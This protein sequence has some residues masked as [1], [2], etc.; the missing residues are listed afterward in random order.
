LFH[1]IIHFHYL[2]PFHYSST[3]LD[4]GTRWTWV[5]IF[6]LKPLYSRGKRP[7]YP[8]DRK[9]GGPQS[10]SG[11]CGIKKRSLVPAENRTPAC[12]RSQYRLSCS[13]S[14]DL[15]ETELWIENINQ[16][17]VQLW[18][19]PWP[20]ITHFA[21]NELK[22]SYKVSVRIAN[23]NY[24]VLL[25]GRWGRYLDSASVVQARTVLF[26]VCLFIL[27]F[28]LSQCCRNWVGVVTGWRPGFDSR[29]GK[30][31]TTSRHGK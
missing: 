7:C 9:L 17:A 31:N 8:L 22:T 27:R 3:I 4:F 28:S 26:V 12:S 6:T 23:T 21:P 30:D 19:N 11:R 15:T 5:V 10:R 18:W 2:F 16:S 29:Q 1:F 14:G 20:F 25:C 24:D 13:G